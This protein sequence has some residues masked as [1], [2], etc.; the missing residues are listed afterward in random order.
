MKSLRFLERGKSRKA[1]EFMEVRRKSSYLMGTT[2]CMGV[3]RTGRIHSWGS[4]SGHV[5]DRCGKLIRCMRRNI[6]NR[7]ARL[8]DQGGGGG[9]DIEAGDSSGKRSRRGSIEGIGET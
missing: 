9:S 2:K 1:K 6:I 5:D 4:I 7:R 8:R 3:I